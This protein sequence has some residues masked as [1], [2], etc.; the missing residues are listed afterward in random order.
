MELGSGEFH[1]R[2]SVLARLTIIIVRRASK[3][4]I[5]KLVYEKIVYLDL[6]DSA[7]LF[8]FLAVENRHVAD[9]GD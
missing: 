9:D 3:C 2:R 4:F 5:N 6:L 1:Q 8:K 7:E